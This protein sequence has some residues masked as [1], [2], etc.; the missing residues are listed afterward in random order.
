M[1]E[2]LWSGRGTHRH[3]REWKVKAALFFLSDNGFSLSFH[4]PLYPFLGYY[5]FFKKKM[6][7]R[8]LVQCHFSNV[9]FY[10]GGVLPDASRHEGAWRWLEGMYQKREGKWMYIFTHEYNR[11]D[12]FIEMLANPYFQELCPFVSVRVTSWLCIPRHLRSV[13]HAWDASRRTRRA[14]CELSASAR[15]CCLRLASSHELAAVKNQKGEL[16]MHQSTSYQG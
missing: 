1:A 5:F 16:T 11:R 12:T 13:A 10:S 6:L 9:G 3:E 2:V 4:I 8:E 14:G 15:S 7:G